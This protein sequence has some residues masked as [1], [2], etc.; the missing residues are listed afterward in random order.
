MAVNISRTYDRFASPPISSMIGDAG[1]IGAKHI[2]PSTPLARTPD[3]RPGAAGKGDRPGNRALGPRRP[4]ACL[5]GA[6]PALR[7]ADLLPGLP[8]GP[9][10]GAGGRP[11]AGNL[12]QG[13]QRAR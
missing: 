12:H 9:R 3:D 5:P 10:P 11:V 4:G 7:T 1:V 13:A 6:D 8:D 2:G